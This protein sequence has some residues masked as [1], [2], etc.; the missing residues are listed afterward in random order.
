MIYAAGA[1]GRVLPRRAAPLFTLDQSSTAQMVPNTLTLYPL[2]LSDGIIVVEAKFFFFTRRMKS[3]LKSYHSLADQLSSVSP[4]LAKNL[5]EP[6]D[7]GPVFP[8]PKGPSLVFV[9]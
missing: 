1:L 3:A 2:F 7:E 9:S 4:N 6:C 8:L 5:E